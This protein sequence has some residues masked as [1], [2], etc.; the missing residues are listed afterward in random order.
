MSVRSG[1]ETPNPPQRGSGTATSPPVESETP[2]RWSLQVLGGFRLTN[3]AGQEIAL[4]G[5]FDPALLTYLALNPKKHGHHREVLSTLLWEARDTSSRSLS[6][7]L[8][9]L[10]NAL[11][12]KDGSVIRHGEPV[13]TDFGA[14]TIDAV[15]FSDLAKKADREALERAE[16]IYAGELLEGFDTH[17][18]EFEE[19]ISGERTRLRELRVDVLRRLVHLRAEA[20]ETDGAIDTAQR[21]LRLDSLNE[22]GHRLLIRLHLRAGR[23]SAAL[24]AAEACEETLRQIKVDP[25]PET[26]RV[27]ADLRR[28]IPADATEPAPKPSI[29]PP[30]VVPD[31][32][33]RPP[34]TAPGPAPPHQVRLQRWLILGVVLLFLGGTFV[35]GKLM[36]Q[37]W[38]IPWLAPNPIDDVITEVK[39]L[40]PGKVQPRVAVLPFASPADNRTPEALAG[41]SG[42]I[43]SALGAVSEMFVIN[44]VWAPPLGENPPDPRQIAND[45]GVRYL[46]LGSVQRSG[47]QVRVTVRLVDT[48]AEAGPELFS[49]T[50]SGTTNDLLGFG[51]RDKITLDAITEAQVKL[52]VG[53]Q[54]RV[55]MER[56][57]AIRGTGNL[58]AY[59]A[60]SEGL[61][62]L[63]HLTPEDNAR[64]RSLYK[65]AISLDKSYAGAYEGLAWTYL[66]DAEFGW[67]SSKIQSFAQAQLLTRKALQLDPE[68]ARLYSLRGH[69]NLLLRNFQQA[70]DD[71]E[72]AVE[73]ERN[74]A[75]AAA[76]L[77]FT[78]TY[79]GEPKRAKQLLGHA[80]DLSPSYPAWYGWALGR[81]YRLD[82]EPARAV[83]TLE[84]NLPERPTSI[85][86]LVELVIAYSEAGEAALAKATAAAIRDKV[87]NFSVGAWA[88]AQ[89]YE[90]PAMTE[91]DAAALRAAGLPD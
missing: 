58:P 9:K 40:L 2:K 59:L 52:T 80:I 64:A 56:L 65:E 32:P 70:V 76:L 47:D 26:K 14:M 67:T 19:W 3:G 72:H 21:L 1:S 30:P 33:D 71:G 85:I 66:L 51:F 63:R 83:R 36:W 31:I 50:H 6:V 68:K 16:T 87:P 25:E 73:T 90:D 27:I 82:G 55:T 53:I 42:D 13:V 8:N 12:D 15:M 7:S 43:G 89:P 39:A 4:P 20:G 28:S 77:A 62:L 24:K 69:L 44:A 88:A 84:R 60:A 79:T 41:L 74:D 91:Q 11:G 61:K 45:L 54:E 57:T 23:R 78:L 17:T 29:G 22:E 34:E 5:S 75:D 46:L 86:P 49:R 18:D 10:R 81:A 37:Y 38:N 35:L 48:D